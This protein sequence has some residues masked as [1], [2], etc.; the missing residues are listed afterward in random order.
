MV[1]GIEKPRAN[2]ILATGISE[3]I[4]SEIN[5]GYRDPSTINMEDYADREEEGVLLVRKAGEMLHR[6][7][8][9]PMWALP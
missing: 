5:L 1:N 8:D 9:P 4:C 3:E 7:N 6:L 2:V